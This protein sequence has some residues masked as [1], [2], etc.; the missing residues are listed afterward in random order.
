MTSHRIELRKL[1]IKNKFMAKELDLPFVPTQG[2]TLDAGLETVRLDKL[3]YDG[4]KFVGTE[5]PDIKEILNRVTCDFETEQRIIKETVSR[6]QDQGWT[7]L[8]G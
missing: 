6:Y 5:E 7:Q 1:I 2:L 3:V 8:G 4:K